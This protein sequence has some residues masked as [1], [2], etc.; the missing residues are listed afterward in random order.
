MTDEELLER[1]DTLADSIADGTVAAE[2]D[3]DSIE[4]LHLTELGKALFRL[5]SA[6]SYP[7]RPQCNCIIFKNP[8]VNVDS[9]TLNSLPTHK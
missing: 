8:V 1:I 4:L 6:L 7:A 2:V 9:S 3:R 5:P